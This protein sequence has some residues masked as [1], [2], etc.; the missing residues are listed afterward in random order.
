LKV[1]ALFGRLSGDG[2]EFRISATAC[3]QIGVWRTANTTLHLDIPNLP[4]YLRNVLTL[5][6]P[7]YSWTN[8]VE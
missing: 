7:K 5:P 1:K 2:T 4:L 8:S 3:L 6:S